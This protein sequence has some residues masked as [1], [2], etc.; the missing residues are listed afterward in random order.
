MPAPPSPP[1]IKILSRY[2]LFGQPPAAAGHYISR[3]GVSFIDAAASLQIRL[4]QLRIAIADYIFIA[5][6]VSCRYAAWY[7]SSFRLGFS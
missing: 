6:H 2:F 1:P 7:A 3:H 4:R 5:G